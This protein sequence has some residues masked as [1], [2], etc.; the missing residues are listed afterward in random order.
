[1]PLAVLDP[2]FVGGVTVGKATLH[3]QEDIARKGL[4]VGD[5]VI[6][7]RAGD[8]IP[9]VVGPLMQERTGEERRPF[10]MPRR[11]PA[12]GT[13]VVKPE[14]EVFTLCPNRVRARSSPSS[15]RALRR[16]GRWTSRGWARSR[17]SLPAT[18]G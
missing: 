9:Q 7:L 12:C 14:G 5:Q 2:V 11:C 10:A 3:N 4:L 13:P 16:A 1:M 15:T 17:P 18:R 6:V 8:V